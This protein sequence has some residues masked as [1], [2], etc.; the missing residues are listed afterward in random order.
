VTASVGLKQFVGREAR[1]LL[2]VA[3]GDLGKIVIDSPQGQLELA[4]RTQDSAAIPRGALVLI[5]DVN[6][7]TANVTSMPTLERTQQVRLTERT[8]Q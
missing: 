8:P 4:A 3:P 7:G 6:D 1:V 5:T 2:P